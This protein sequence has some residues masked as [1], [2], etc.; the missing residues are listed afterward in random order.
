M[1]RHICYYYQRYQTGNSANVL[2]FINDLCMKVIFAN[3]TKSVTI[4]SQFKLFFRAIYISAKIF[5][6]IKTPSII[7]Y[8]I[9]NC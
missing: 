4:N 8:Y 7:I 6:D 3:N 2:L 1:Y 9:I 5:P